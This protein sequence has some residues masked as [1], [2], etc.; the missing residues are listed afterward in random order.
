MLKNATSN[1]NCTNYHVVVRGMGKAF[2]AIPLH[3]RQGIT[4]VLLG[5]L[6]KSASVINAPVC[7]QGIQS[8]AQWL[9]ANLGPFSPYTTYADLKVFNLSGVA[10]V[11]SLSPKQKAELILD[12]GSGALDNE[13]IVREVF[14]SL[15]ESPD[16]EQLNQFFQAFTKINQQRNTTLIVNPDVRATILNLTLTALAPEFEDF[17]P[18]DFELWFQ[19]NLA[20]VL[21]SLSPGSLVVI[22]GNIS[23]ASYAAI[24]TGLQQSLRSLPLHVSQGVRS[25]A[26][27][28]KKRFT[29][30]LTHFFT[31]IQLP[32]P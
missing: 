11:D 3:R 19:V 4:D 28:L 30:T 9:E 16:D 21:A 18:K 25:S 7:R 17:E 31:K 27:S 2:P 32:L 26:E 5:Y 12:P 24:L 6:R 13:T 1:I 22:P 20:T 8:D 23:C 10:V 15:T 14:T 29:R